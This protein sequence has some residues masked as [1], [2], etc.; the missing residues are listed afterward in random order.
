MDRNT[1]KKNYTTRIKKSNY[2]YDSYDEDIEQCSE[3]RFERLKCQIQGIFAVSSAIRDF[4]LENVLEI[5][6]Y[7]YPKD[8][9]DIL[10]HGDFT[11]Y[12]NRRLR[13]VV[14]L[15]EDVVVVLVKEKGLLIGYGFASRDENGEMV[16]DV[17]DVD[18]YS[19]RM[20][21]LLK[22]IMLEEKKFE[23]GVGHVIVQRLIDNCDRP[24]YADVVD[25]SSSYVLKSLGF[26]Y[27][28]KFSI[29][30]CILKLE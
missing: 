10:I 26:L 16:V 23:I 19:R 5:E 2:P 20:S 18:L 12:D 17:I 14:P 1:R 6:V 3:K 27:T 13:D 28:N 29:N 25:E 22:R 21:G 24:I 9:P 11:Y 30:Y 15:A 4:E 8:I 7:R